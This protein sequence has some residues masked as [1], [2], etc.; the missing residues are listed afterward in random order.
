MEKPAEKQGILIGGLAVGI[1]V[2]M[3]IGLWIKDELSYEDYHD[4][5][6]RIALVMQ[7]Q[8]FNGI[9]RTGNS[10]P[11]PLAGE[12]QKSYGDEF[13]HVVMSWWM[14]DHSHV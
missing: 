1:A 2:A 6:D 8:T 7:H 11:Y 10:V 3:L 12:I 9:R 13:K 4:R 14:G 5:R